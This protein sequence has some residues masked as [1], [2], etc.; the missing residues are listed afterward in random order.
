MV[1][2]HKPL[3]DTLTLDTDDSSIPLGICSS[4]QTYG[5]MGG[6]AV[7]NDNP[8]QQGWVGSENSTAQ[9]CANAEDCYP[10]RLVN[11]EGVDILVEPGVHHFQIN[12]QFARD[13][14]HVALDGPELSPTF[15]EAHGNGTYTASYCVELPG[16]YK[17]HAALV[18]LFT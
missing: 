12:S 2:Q 8:V 3:H 4:W 17:L 1:V 9:E 16:F 11:V 10:G 5:T 18:S 13:E 7:M 6:R 15:V 14:F